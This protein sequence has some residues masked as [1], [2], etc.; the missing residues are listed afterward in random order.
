MVR[1]SIVAAVVV[2]LALALAPSAFADEHGTNRPFRM[3][4]SAT[5]HWEFEPL[6]GC[7]VQTVTDGTSDVPHLGT[8]TLHFSH[9]P[10]LAPGELY[11]DGRATITAANGD[12]LKMDYDFNGEPPYAGTIT[13]G[14]G[15][16]EGATGHVL[17]TVEFTWAPWGDDGL[18]LAP[19]YA[20]F[21]WWGTINY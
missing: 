16:F 4:T 3:D 7:A 13:G 5:I 20:D 18:P 10:P 21:H 9:C 17:Y 1:R 2:I 8:A 15:R 12:T 6:P 14:T 19:W 11:H